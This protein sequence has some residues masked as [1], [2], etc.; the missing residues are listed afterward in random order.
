MSEVGGFDW[1]MDP[2]PLDVIRGRGYVRRGTDANGDLIIDRIP[3]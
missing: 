2:E 1:Y 3:H